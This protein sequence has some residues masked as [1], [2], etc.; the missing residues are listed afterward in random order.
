MTQPSLSSRS[1]QVPDTVE[2]IEYYYEQGLTDGLPVIPPTPERVAQFLDYVHKE[3]GDVIGSVPTRQRVITAEKVAI[4]AIMAGCLPEYMP[5][6][7]TAVEAMCEE[8]F[9]L[10]GTS[11]STAGSGHMVI[12][13][14]PIVKELDINYANNIFG[15]TKRSNATIGRAIRLILMNVCGSIPGVLDKSTFGHPGKYSYCIAE[16]EDLSPWEPL[17][18][19]RGLPLDSRAVTVFAPYAPLQQDDHSSH[20]AEGILTSVARGMLSLAYPNGGEFMV[21]LGPEHIG[22]I[23]NQ[24]WSKKQVREFLFEATKRPTSFWRGQGR[25]AWGR[26]TMGD[27][28]EAAAVASPDDIMVLVAGG[29]AGAFFCC[30]MPWGAGFNTK[31]VT[32]PIPNI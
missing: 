32:K 26:G 12:V 8:K 9:N 24:G 19:E 17:H 31:S 21:I 11:A 27:D 2:A 15:P 18:V 29:S 16:N 3:P 30:I 13:H 4:N 7:V 28:Q 25:E 20:D 14:G 10:H 6:V 22:Y 23:R 1:Y 5:V